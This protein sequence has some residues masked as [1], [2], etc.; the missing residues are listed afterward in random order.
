MADGGKTDMSRA[1]TDVQ[2]AEIVSASVAI[3]DPGMAKSW[4]YDASKSSRLKIDVEEVWEDYRGE[5]VKVAV[6][7]SMVDFLHEDLTDTYDSTLD[8]DLGAGSGDLEMPGKRRYLDEHGTAVAGIIAADDNDISSV[9]IAPEARLASLAMDYRASNVAEQAVEGLRMAANVDVVN[10]SWSFTT[11]FADNFNTDTEYAQAVEHT[12]SEGRDG[13]GTVMVFSAGNSGEGGWSNYHSFQNSPFTIAVGAVD[14]DGGASS[15]TSTGANVL[16]SAAGSRVFS[17]ATNDRY[18]GVQGTSFSAPIVSG[19][20]ALMLE[21]NSGLGYRDVQQILALSARKDGLDEDTD[22]GTGWTTNGATNFNG[23]G[24]HVSDAFGYGFV[25]AH[26]AVRLAETW[27]ETSTVENRESVRVS[28]SFKAI[29][30]SAGTVDHVQ[31]TLEVTEE[32]SVEHAQLQLNLSRRDINDLEITLTSP[33]GTVSTLVHSGDREIDQ[34]LVNFPFSTVAAMGEEAKGTW[35][36]DIVNTNPDAVKD[37]GAPVGGAVKGVTL[38]LHG[39]SDDADDTYVYT[40]E[41]GVLYSEAEL[42]GRRTL[43]DTDGGVDAINAAPVTSDVLIDLRAGADSTIAGQTVTL[44]EGTIENAFAGDGNDTLRGNEGDN[45][46][47]GGRGDD[48][49]TVTAGSDRIWGEDGYDVADIDVSFSNVAG[50]VGEFGETVLEFVLD[51]IDSVTSFLGI[52]LFRF[53]DATLTAEDLAGTLDGSGPSRPDPETSTDD[54]ADTGNDDTGSGDTNDGG[55]ADPEPRPEPRP[56]PEPEPPVYEV[57]EMPETFE[58]RTGSRA[59]DMV[60][61]GKTSDELIGLA[62]DDKL[63]AKGGDDVLRGGDG[64]DYLSGDAGDDWLFGGEGRDFL[65]GGD[66]DDRL[67]ADA[68]GDGLVGGKGADVFVIESSALGFTTS[69]RDFNVEDGDIIDLSAIHDMVGSADL[70]LRHSSRTTTVVAEVDGAEVDLLMVK[71]TTL[72]GT[73]FDELL[74]GDSLLL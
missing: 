32:M 46:L 69:I 14:R 54:D 2:Q 38:T 11:P 7:D 5:G 61:G 52:E 25:N 59:A 21:A 30:M 72:H 17:T 20:A 26:D 68:G 53:S 67:F 6:L 8:Y 9:G 41:F 1:N 44:G 36:I 56:E 24:M 29:R 18:E 57:V 62:G 45:W 49:F 39:D 15:F 47:R 71:N 23:G 73:T 43:D 58:T 22:H 16:V 13:L 3:N 42:K 50:T 65:K 64:N 35:T 40:D 33:S 28:D 70:S 37:N 34:S 4:Y 19:V 10:C 51:A 63:V 66:G 27:T 60:R 12:A 74:S 48:S 31:L 55:D